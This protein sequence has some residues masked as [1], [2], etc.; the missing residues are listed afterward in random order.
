MN[1]V[2]T[3]QKARPHALFVVWFAYSRRSQL[4]ADKLHIKMCPIQSLKRHYIFAP[5]RYVLQAVRTFALLVR[6]R[7][8]LVFVQNP[9]I[10]AAMVVYLYAK[11]WKAKYIIDS[12][13]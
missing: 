9:P 5:V 10:F 8:R 11:L 1:R 3:K 6:Q 13:T 12:L 4:I 7:P 2:D